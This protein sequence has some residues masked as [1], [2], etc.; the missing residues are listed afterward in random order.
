MTI[1]FSRSGRTSALGKNVN[2]VGT[3]VSDPTLSALEELAQKTG[4]PR[5]ETHREILDQALFGAVRSIPAIAAGR[6]ITLEAAE[7]AMAALSGMSADEYRQHVM[8]VHLFGALYVEQIVNADADAEQTT[9]DRH[10]GA[11]FVPISVPG[12]RA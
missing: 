1:Q 9:N 2:R 3:D 12:R 8:A 4:R 11:G 10:I 5:A 6:R 7:T